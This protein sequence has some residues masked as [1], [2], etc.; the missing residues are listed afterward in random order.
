MARRNPP[1][2]RPWQYKSKLFIPIAKN[3]HRSIILAIK[4]AGGTKEYWNKLPDVPSVVL[5]R[6]PMDRLHSAYR[7]FLAKGETHS[8]FDEFVRQLLS[9]KKIDKVL[10]CDIHLK[11][12]WESMGAYSPDIVVKWDFAKLES[13]LGVKIPHVG[14]GVFDGDRVL[15]SESRQLFDDYYRKDVELWHDGHTD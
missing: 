11:T 6:E 5:L 9:G 15:S 13:V 4:E 1:A 8:S 2:L 10:P 14:M 12:Q 7:M 3:A